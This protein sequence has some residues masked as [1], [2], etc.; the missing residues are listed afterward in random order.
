MKKSFVLVI[1]PCIF[2]SYSVYLSAGRRRKKQTVPLNVLHEGK[3]TKILVYKEGGNSLKNNK[4]RLFEGIQNGDVAVVKDLIELIDDINVKN[5]RGNTPIYLAANKFAEVGTFSSRKI[6]RILLDKQPDT[7]IVTATIL[8]FFDRKKKLK[9]SF[10]KKV[11]DLVETKS[12][13]EFKIF[14]EQIQRFIKDQTKA[15]ILYLA[16]KFGKL[17]IV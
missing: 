15:Y 11:N 5:E 3:S 4:Q 17:D 9:K 1:I 7:D 6:V 16:C 13:K 14:F 12:V 10:K 8:R 2:F